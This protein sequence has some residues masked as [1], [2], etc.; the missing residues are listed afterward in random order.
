MCRSL[1]N[2]TLPSFVR[3]ALCAAYATLPA[4]TAAQPAGVNPLGWSDAATAQLRGAVAEV[5]ATTWSVD[6]ARRTV[7]KAAQTARTVDT[8]GEQGQILARQTFDSDGQPD[9]KTV[10]Q[11]EPDGRKRVS[12]T[13]SAAGDRTLQTLYAYTADG[14]LARMRFTDAD[15]VTISTTEV[16]T[17]ERWAQTVELFKDGEKVTTTYIFDDNGRLAETRRSDGHFLSTL[18]HTMG[19]NGLPT[20]GV[21]VASDGR[22]ATLTYE[23]ETD[24]WGNWTLRTTY[25]DGVATELTER[26]LRYR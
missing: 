8:Y 10:Y 18:R 6:F 21:F 13:Y 15:A 5:E 9:A 7:V 1:N 22:R 19:L 20:R 12:T 2:R 25:V 23:Y 3:L 16:G 14:C 24:G 26:R 17:A 4:V 11:Y